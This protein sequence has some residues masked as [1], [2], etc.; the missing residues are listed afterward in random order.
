MIETTDG[1]HFTGDDRADRLLVTDPMALLIGF[2][3]DQ[4]VP[5]QKAFSGPQVLL[6]RL[7]SIDAKQLASIDMEDLER[8]A[9]GPPAIHRFPSAMAKRVRELATHIAD[10]YDGDAA[11]VWTDASDGHDLERR[12]GAMPG[13]GEMKVR[14]LIA[15]LVKRLGVSLL[16]LDDVMPSYPTLGD[17]DSPQAL[18]DYQAKKRAY[19]AQLRESGEKFE[20]WA[21][22]AEAADYAKGSR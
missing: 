3:L 14:S 19:K 7:G 21:D 5:V 6:D 16:G 12:I 8:A 20:P 1:L 22:R 4:Q 9:K 2:A 11:R 13:F 18:A 15:V 10:T 17:V